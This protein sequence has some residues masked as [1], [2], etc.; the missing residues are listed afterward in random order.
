[1]FNREDTTS[2]VV[3]LV[4]R[5]R[6]TNP[7]Y[8]YEISISREGIGIDGRWPIMSKEQS[9]IVEE[10]LTRARWHH[11]HLLH[12]YEYAPR[13]RVSLTE[14]EITDL[15]TKHIPLYDADEAQ[16]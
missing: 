10:H 11:S 7:R 14:D 9:V 15:I 4:I 5:Y 2:V 6:S 1:M 8:T 3:G 16:P 12:W 13:D